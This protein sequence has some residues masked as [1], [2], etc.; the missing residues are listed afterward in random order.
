MIEH[1][2]F[3]MAPSHDTIDLQFF[4][5]DRLFYAMSAGHGRIMF[6]AN[7]EDMK[8]LL[9][10]WNKLFKQAEEIVNG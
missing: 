4:E 3:L 2:T 8:T 6:R 7:M 1:R 5:D 10:A 9:E